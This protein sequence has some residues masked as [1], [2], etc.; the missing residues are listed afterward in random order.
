MTEPQKRYGW[1]IVAIAILSLVVSNGLAIGGLPPFYKPIREDFVDI[2]AIDASRAESFIGNSAN[3]TFLLSGV[4]SLIGGWFISRTGL[5]AV[6]LIG[7][8]LLGGGLVIHSQAS[9]AEVVYAARALMGASLGFIGVA[10]CVVLVSRWFDKGRGTA[11]GIVL[12]GTSL[13][14]ALIPLVAAPLITRYGWRFA[15]IALTSIIW[16]ILV[17]AIAFFIKEPVENTATVTDADAANGMTL[18]EAIR[19]PLFWAFGVC[20][21]LV[22]YPIFVTSQQFILYLQTPKIGVSAETAAFA[23]SALFAISIGGKFLAGTLSDKFRAIRVMVGCSL[24]MFAASLVLLGL[25]AENSLYFLLPFAIGYGGTFVLLQ[26][27][28]ADFF[29][30]R[31]IGKILGLI[32]LIEVTGAAIGGRITGYLADRNGGDY[33]FAF[34]GVTIAAGLAFVATLAIYA[35]RKD[36]SP[37]SA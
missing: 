24:L 22:F 25:T 21:A 16:L 33:T 12:T 6:M 8:V 32:T 23:Q 10:P 27:L 36:R 17:P 9:S 14:G 15:M 35:L 37:S 26:R 30:R 3:I 11:L 18:A 4:F 1:V 29:G 7:C 19:E 5:K 34:Y 28:A 20:A 13:G 2:G 31:E